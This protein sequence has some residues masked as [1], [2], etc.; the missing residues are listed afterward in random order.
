MRATRPPDDR[1]ARHE[2]TGEWPQPSLW[3][4]LAE[5]VRRTPDRTYVIEG[6]RD[7]G[8][9]WSFAD[10]A[11]RAE[12]MAGALLGLGVR[13]GDVVSW[14]LPNWFEGAALAAAIDRVGAV[15]NPILTIY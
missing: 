8:R 2:A 11:A 6:L 7:G 12:R 14:Q 13:P 5:R 1:C 10:L 4:L 3:A 15:S 9:S